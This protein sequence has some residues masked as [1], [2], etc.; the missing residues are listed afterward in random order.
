LRDVVVGETVSKNP[1]EPFEAISHLFEPV[2]TKSICAKRTADL[3][4]LIEILRQVGKED[5]SLRIEINEE[6]GESLMSGM[7]ELHLEII[8]NRIKTEKGLEIEM[9][10]QLC[11]QRSCC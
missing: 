6:T 5:P 4:K 1:I 9:G 2:V 10:P 8:E 11:L 3:P 7:G